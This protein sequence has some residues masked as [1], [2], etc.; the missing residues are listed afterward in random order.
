VLYVIC[1]TLF[2]C[3]FV[4]RISD[5]LTERSLFSRTA[6]TKIGTAYFVNVIFLA[7]SLPK[8]RISI[9]VA[10]FLPMLLFAAVLF[11]V[12]RRRSTQFREKF[13][14]ILTLVALKMKAGRSFRQ[15]YSEVAAESSP[16]IRAKLGEIGSVVVFSQQNKSTPRTIVGDRFIAEVVD[17]LTRIDQQ[18]HAAS[19]RLAIFREKL[20]LESDFRRRSGLVVARIRVQSLIMSLMYLALGGFSIWHYGWLSYRFCY[21]ISATFFV[22]GGLWIWLW[23]RNL[24]WKV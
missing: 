10:I 11:V 20:R 22:A 14:E 8:T 5:F 12:I 19:K 6:L 21:L 17:E 9:W 7:L 24:K 15:S 2:G 1:C 13:L 16:E 18:P 23:G 4:V 3:A